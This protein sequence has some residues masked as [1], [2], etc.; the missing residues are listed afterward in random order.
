MKL[1][2]LGLKIGP[3]IPP[4]KELGATE[5][6]ANLTQLAS[7]FHDL[8]S[9]DVAEFTRIANNV[10]VN[11][12]PAGP[13]LRDIA[14]TLS[15]VAALMNA[16]KASKTLESINVA[17]SCLPTP[18]L[19]NIPFAIFAEAMKAG[20]KIDIASFYLERL[21]SSVGSEAFDLVFTELKADKRVK[22]AELVTIA[23]QFVSHTARSA[24]K[25]KTLERI[26]SRHAS[27]VDSANKRE[28]QRGKSAA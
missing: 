17:L 5:A 10:E 15:N 8:R 14:L 2:K 24:P 7:L 21:E 6:E 11:G 22:Q 28:W 13:F 1:G 26:Y 9:E 23:S 25:A 18:R 19:D 3:L 27:L 4:L 16:A 12:G 20:M